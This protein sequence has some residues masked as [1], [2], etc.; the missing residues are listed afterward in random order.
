MAIRGKELLSAAAGI[1]LRLEGREH[2]SDLVEA[3]AIGTR[4]GTSV[5]SHLEAATWHYIGH[6]LRDVT[7]AIIMRR[8]ADIERLVMDAAFGGL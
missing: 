5:G 4:V 8:V 6:D 2:A 3:D 1:P 7:D